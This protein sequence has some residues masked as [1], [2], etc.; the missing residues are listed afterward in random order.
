[1]I[2]I[3]LAALGLVCLCPDASA[4]NR[5]PAR[6]VLR[7]IV[8]HRAVHRER[9]VLRSRAPAAKVVQVAVPAAPVVPVKK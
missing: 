7:A 8:P 5:Q 2:R 4:C 3:L 1:M 9:H 6:N